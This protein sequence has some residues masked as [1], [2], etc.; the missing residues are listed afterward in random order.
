MKC[1]GQTA[2]TP[3]ERDTLA[4]IFDSRLVFFVKKPRKPI[5][6]EVW[7]KNV[8]KDRFMGQAVVEIRP[9][10]KPRQSTMRLHAK[11]RPEEFTQGQLSL[12]VLCTDD[13]NSI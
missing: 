2:R 3:V 5:I 8:V 11:G 7:N 12:T 4:P 13:M 9:D 6:V 1:E 10:G